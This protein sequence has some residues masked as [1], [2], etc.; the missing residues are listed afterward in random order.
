MKTEIRVRGQINGNSILC[1]AIQTNNCDARSTNFFGYCLT[2]PT[3]KAAK[4][5]LWEAY[6]Y[7]RSSEPEF[8]KGGGISYSKYGYLSYDASKAEI[9]D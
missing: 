3:K 4:K 6:K 9:V 7:L 2:F 8:A 1:R 5:A